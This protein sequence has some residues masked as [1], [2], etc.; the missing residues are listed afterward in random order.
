VSDPRPP[1]PNV[2]EQSSHST[3]TATL[4]TL[5]RFILQPFSLTAV[6]VVGAILLGVFGATWAAL[7]A[8]VAAVVLLVIGLR[9]T[10]RDAIGV[11]VAGPT[12]RP[13][14]HISVSTP[15]DHAGLTYGHGGHLSPLEAIC[16][17]HLSVREGGSVGRNQIF[18]MDYFVDLMTAALVPSHLELM[19]REL[20][21]HVRRSGK[22][23]EIT[24]A[25]APKRGNALLLVATARELKL[26]PL[27]IKERPLFGKM[28]EGIA[29]QPK[30]AILLDDISSD[31][32]LLV[33]CVKVLRESGYEVTDAFV[34]V[35]RP[36]GDARSALMAVGVTLS[37]LY[38]LGDQDLE[39]IA[40]HG[41][42]TGTL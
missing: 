21:E 7:A 2:E 22:M 33:N 38:S 12:Y 27:F 13:V 18:P 11:L 42:R 31:G 24:T 26:E 14:S 20:V 35:D 4:A 40:A 37:P 3:W 28:I 10:P 9:G 6:A 19:T 25:A 32:E 23:N 5:P 15:V 1:E 16:F 29:G 39:S 30:K 41:R 34:L 8:L 36:E 17:L